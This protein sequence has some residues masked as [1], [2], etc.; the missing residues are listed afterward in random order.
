MA[1]GIGKYSYRNL[2]YIQLANGTNPGGTVLARAD[3]SSLN[4]ANFAGTFQ[5]PTLSFTTGATISG[6]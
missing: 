3:V 5:D 6:I 1:I 2:G 4:M